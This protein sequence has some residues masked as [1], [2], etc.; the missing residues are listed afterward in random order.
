M[1]TEAL[2][3]MARMAATVLILGV[4]PPEML[5]AR[6][7]SEADET[8][9]LPDGTIARLGKGG[10]G[11]GDRAVAFSPVDQGLAVASGIGIWLYDVGTSRVLALLPTCVF[12]HFRVVFTRRDDARFFTR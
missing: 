3:A 9:H 6:G 11:E 5:L 2:Q 4:C 7:V 1:R 10:L 8:R 12:C